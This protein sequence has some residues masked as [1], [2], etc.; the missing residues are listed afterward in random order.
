[1]YTLNI[2]DELLHRAEEI[3]R[4][5]ERPVEDV[6]LRQLQGLLLPM[7]QADEY[8]ELEAFDLLSDDMLW[9]IAREQLPVAIRERM[10]Q[11]MDRNS[12]GGITDSEY[13]ELRELVERGNR[14]TLRKARAAAVLTRRGLAVT[15]D[16]LSPDADA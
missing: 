14:L 2:P 15:L 11:L 16:H 7:L 5:T 13:T 12:D 3:A 4:D 10:S 9:T 8:A 1:M 6:L